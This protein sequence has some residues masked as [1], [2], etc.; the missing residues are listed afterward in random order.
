MQKVVISRGE[1]LVLLRMSG[2]GPN[3]IHVASHDLLEVEFESPLEDRVP[4]RPH[5]K[6]AAFALTNS[7]DRTK[8]FRQLKKS[9]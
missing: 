1:E 6:L 9:K 7:S 2:Q 8:M 3:L 4:G 5:H